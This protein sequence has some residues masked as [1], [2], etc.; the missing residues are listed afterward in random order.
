MPEK[1]N[2]AIFWDFDGTLVH[3]DA[4]WSNSFLAA[5][6]EVDP[7]SPLSLNDIRPFMQSCFTW[8]N[9]E[10]DYTQITGP[11][12]WVYMEA[13][14]EIIA[15]QLG[16][17]INKA[18]ETANRVRGQVLRSERYNVFPDALHTLDAAKAKGWRSYVLSNN[19]PELEE[20]AKS[21]G[22]T[23]K[24]EGFVVSS[25]VGYEKPRREIFDAALCMAGYPQTA[26]MI[27]DNPKSDIDGGNSVGL[28][29]I[30]VHKAH[31]RAA[32]HCLKDLADLIEIL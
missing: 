15:S 26:F 3:S 21:L 2:K 16:M 12:W 18:K 22:L 8:D 29:T 13:R 10:S 30:L 9:P 27:G 5:L 14:F 6:K 4:P 28:T 7:D 31:Y 19:Y 1:L 11:K 23:N 32:N 20:T 17:P 25:L 24:F